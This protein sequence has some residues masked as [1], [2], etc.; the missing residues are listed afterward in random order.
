VQ[1]IAADW[2]A[3]GVLA[4]T[5][6]RAGGVSEGV[7]ASLNLGAQVG[8][9]PAAVAE[10]RRRLVAG[11]ALAE[12]PRW[13]MQVHGAAVVRS[14]SATF[15]DGPPAADA[16]VCHDGEAVLGILTADCLPVLLADTGTPATAAMHC[17][18]RSLAGGI[19]EATVASL[20]VGTDGLLAWL[21]PAISQ[22]A[23]EVGDEVRDL[24]LAGL[25]GASTCFYQ[26]ARGRWQADLYALARLY[27]ARAGVR[28]VYGG[29]RC[30]YDEPDRFYSY[31]R[32]GPC[33]RLATV[34]ARRGEIPS[35]SV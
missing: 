11:L 20:Q 3:A 35:A 33:G 16:V 31:R 18:W 28:Q 7:Y 4:G 8:D 23:F 13:L 34:I 22:P 14:D 5:T 27:L 26:N 12:E 6:T 25:E 10:N 9:D 29:G 2:P 15:L 24:F 17:G 30:T 1:L 32:D 19:V 21:G